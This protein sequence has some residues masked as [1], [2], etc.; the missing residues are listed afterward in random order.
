[1][2][3]DRLRARSWRAVSRPRPALEPVITAD[4]PWRLMF[5]GRGVTLG[6]KSGMLEVN[7]CARGLD[8]RVVLRRKVGEL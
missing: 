8:I 2:S 1:M 5:E 3:V 4:L 6:W 7:R